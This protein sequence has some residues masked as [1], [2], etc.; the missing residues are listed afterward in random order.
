MS[1]LTPEIRE[2]AL[3]W[4]SDPVF[5]DA[6]R[7]EIKQLLDSNSTK[8]LDDRFYRDLEFGTGG[9]RGIVGAGTS[10]MNIYN[11]RK[12]ATALSQYVLATDKSG[13]PKIAIAYDSRTH[14]RMFAEATAEVFAANGIKTLITKELRPVPMLSYMVRHFSCNAGVC[15]TASHNPPM[16]NGFKVYWNTGGQVVQ[17]HDQEIIRRYYGIT[18]YGSLKHIPFAEAL[19]SGKIQEIGNDFDELYFEK[20]A[21]LS[22]S[23]EGRKNFKIAFTPLHGTAA[24]PVRE[25][26]KRYG[27]TD[28]HVVPEQEK[29]DGNFPTVKFPNPEEAEAL[30]MAVELGK[31]IDADIVL[32]TDPD[33]DRVGI[34]VREGKDF[35]YLNGNQIGCLMT[36]FYMMRMK[37]LKKLPTNPLV[38][39]TIVT[40]DLQNKIAEYYGAHVDETL[41]G[42][43]WICQVI[44]DYETGKLTPKRN[45]VCGGEESYGFLADS[46]VR[47]KDGVSACCIAAEMVAHYKAQGLSMMKVLDKIYRRH[48]VYQELLTT[49]TLPGKEGAEKI[50]SMMKLF[51]ETPPKELAGSQVHMI[52]D[53]KTGK[54]LTLDGG[55]FKQSRALTLPSSDVLQFFL[56]DGSKVSARPSGTEPKIKFYVS[57]RT[58][59]SATI[60]DSDLERIKSQCQQ[61]TKTIVEQF[62][63]LA[64]SV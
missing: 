36:E 57:V 23:K 59:V 51:R 34:V 45:Y 47:D 37:E 62:T 5:D 40:T 18:S 4:S 17:P 8:D 20:V 11:I 55:S 6:T 15:V 53:I 25:C 2:R 12:A 54:E 21:S 58:D 27:F 61:R 3:Y 52:R 41:T 64:A 56:A 9:L 46:F 50:Q 28:V 22:L 7:R 60:S 10:R 49:I 43:K 35:V 32:G 13:T 30:H 16:Y 33:C 31:K 44:D 48:G 1:Q 42:F 14:S 29:P 24:Y 39:K 26:L 63:K 19:S 38:V